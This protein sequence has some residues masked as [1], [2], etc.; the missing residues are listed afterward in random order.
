MPDTFSVI[1][2][3]PLAYPGFGGFPQPN[4]DAAQPQLGRFRYWRADHN[5]VRYLIGYTAARVTVNGRTMFAYVLQAE[6]REVDFRTFPTRWQAKDFAWWVYCSMT[7]RKWQSLH[8]R[9]SRA[10][11]PCPECG[12]PFESH[13]TL[14]SHRQ[15]EHG[16]HGSPPS[17]PTEES[18]IVADEIARAFESGLKG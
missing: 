4:I 10:M 16:P 5:G 17:S 6:G 7:G 12:Q 13:A 9:K 18:A 2:K 1:G 14:L 3:S 15:H 8:R 11:W